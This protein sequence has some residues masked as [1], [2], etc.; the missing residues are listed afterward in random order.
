[1]TAANKTL[2]HTFNRNRQFAWI[3]IFLVVLLALKLR[4]IPFG[5]GLGEDEISTAVN[6]VETPSLR[7]TVSDCGGFNN[8]IG[9]SVLAGLTE[10]VLGR[11][12]RSLRLSALLFGLAT[13]PCMFLFCRAFVG[14]GFALLASLLLAISPPH[15]DYSTQVRGYS[16][17]IFCS[18]L[19]S[20]LF[21]RLLQRESSREAL[22]LV[23]A[24]VAGIYI[25][26]YAVF[27]VATQ[28][29]TVT[30]LIR[31]PPSKPDSCLSA[32]AKRL[33]IMS[34]V[35]TAM[36]SLIL[37]F[38]ALLS[39]MR[40]LVGSGRSSFM[41]AFPWEVLKYLSGTENPFITVIGVL[42]AVAGGLDLFRRSSQA[43]AY[44][45]TLF[46]APLLLMWFMRPV[47]LYPRFFLYWLP[48][49]L[50]LVVNGIR[51]V[52]G[53]TSSTFRGNAIR[54]IA[55][56]GILAVMLNW[57]MTWQSW[58]KDEGYRELS[59]IAL[60]GANPDTAFC[61]IG[62]NR[63]IWKYYIKRPIATPLSLPELEQVASA[64]S[65]VRCLYYKAGSQ[66]AAQTEIAA[67]LFQHARWLTC[68]GHTLFQYRVDRPSR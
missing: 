18:T 65:E 2:I 3:A 57:A 60:L 56:A 66:N 51:L 49:Y 29:G 9:Y 8:H 19:S 15:I 41:L 37:Y 23:F 44:M 12:E 68:K 47:F 59:R 38:P 43:L 6:F 52:W 48:F 21:L 26:L 25:H 64:H 54:A 32:G 13:I 1:M 50:L 46:V 62:G 45:V 63:I 58:V 67:F 10:A 7:Q 39:C 34:F 36:G 24:N 42:A 61:A 11:S 5:R 16:G 20:Y 27:V 14:T 22:L 31:R 55:P 28:M 33:L 35:A 53:I 4:L 30:Y 40:V 17:M